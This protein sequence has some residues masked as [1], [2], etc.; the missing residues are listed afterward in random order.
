MRFIRILILL[1]FWICSAQT[2]WSVTDCPAPAGAQDPVEQVSSSDFVQL[3]R[4]Q[5]YGTCPSYT[6]RIQ[7]DGRGVWSG[8]RYVKET[9]GRGATVD[10]SQAVKLIEDFRTHGFWQLCGK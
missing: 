5:C 1:P 8:E 7:G 3:Q 6:V 10:P 2:R 4:T 9:G